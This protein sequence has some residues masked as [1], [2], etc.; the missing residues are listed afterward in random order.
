MIQQILQLWLDK[1]RGLFEILLLSV[2][3]YYGYL[4]FRG[5]IKEMVKTGGINVAPL[6]VEG[7]LLQ[8]P[9]V[10]QAHVVGVPDRDRD[11]VVVAVLELHEAAAADAGAIVAFCRD[12]LASYKVPTR[13][14]FRKA[15]ELP[16][17]PTGKIHKPGLREELTAGGRGAGPQDA[18]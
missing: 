14:V 3:I 10:K 17:T 7:V 9:D 5:R 16:R 4:Y 15:E 18:T 1:W 6:E 12:R 13:F 8:H 11:E 2:G